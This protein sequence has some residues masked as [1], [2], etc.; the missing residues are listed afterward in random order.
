MIEKKMIGEEWEKH[1][2]EEEI[3]QE[4]VLK[5]IVKDTSTIEEK[6]DED[7]KQTVFKLIFETID[8]SNKHF[9][10]IHNEKNLRTYFHD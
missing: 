10:L 2:S 7:L 4:T 5:T 9:Q 1:T 8:G 3:F 6:I